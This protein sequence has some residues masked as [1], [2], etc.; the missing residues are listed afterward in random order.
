MGSWEDA[1]M[2]NTIRAIESMPISSEEKILSIKAAEELVGEILKLQCENAELRAWKEQALAAMKE[3]NEWREKFNSAIVTF[4][5]RYLGWHYL[6]SATDVVRV[7]TELRAKLEAAEWDTKRLDWLQEQ[8]DFVDIRVDP[9]LE[10]TLHICSDA[11]RN[12]SLRQAIDAA[13]AAQKGGAE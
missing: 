11:F 3:N 5:A 12:I 4:D 1:Y 9:D 8:G 2:P 13:V 7:A 10:G 6:Q